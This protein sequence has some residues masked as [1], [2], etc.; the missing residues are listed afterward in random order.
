MRRARPLVKIFYLD[1][2]T[3]TKVFEPAHQRK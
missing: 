3:S 1:R 2:V